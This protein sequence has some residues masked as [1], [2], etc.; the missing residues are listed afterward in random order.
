MVKKLITPLLC[1]F[2]FILTF[3]AQAEKRELN[4]GI[5]GGHNSTEQIGDNLC[6][7]EFLDKE[8]GVDTKLRNAT[9]YQTIIQG[10]LSGKIDA[11]VGFSPSAFAS[12]YLQDPNAVDIVGIQANDADNSRGYYSV[13]IVRADSPYQKLEDLKGTSFAFADPESS[14]GYLIPN[15][16]FKG[17]FGGTSDNNFNDFFKSITFSGGHEQD[18]IGVLNGQFDASVTWTSMIGDKAKGYNSGALKRLVENGFPTLMDDLRIIWVSPLIPDGPSF[19]SNKLPTDFKNKVKAAIH[20]L[21]KENHNCFVKASG[22]QVH[23]EDATIKDFQMAIDLKREQMQ[24]V[25]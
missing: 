8:L 16:Q 13:V 15:H 25:R 14:S 9:D 10:F 22:G 17:K 2:T 18:I 12:I 20:K 5:L 6:V 24:E 7:K 19:V 23:L 21:D 1:I 3:N 11:V 4:L